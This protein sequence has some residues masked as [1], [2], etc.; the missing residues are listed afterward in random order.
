[1]RLRN[2][3]V[4][5]VCIWVSLIAPVHGAHASDAYPARVGRTVSHA[6]WGALGA[7]TLMIGSAGLLTIYDYQGPWH[8]K[9]IYDQHFQNRQV[10]ST[11][12][13]FGALGLSSAALPTLLTGSLIEGRELR[14][15]VPGHTTFS[16]WIAVAAYA[17]GATS[18][19]I[20]TAAWLPGFSVA[21]V[22]LGIIGFSFSIVQFAH[23]AV[24]ARRLPR[25]DKARLYGPRDREKK[26]RVTLA[27][28]ISREHKG[29]ALVGIF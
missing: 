4:A 17:A 13:A 2:I 16:G 1:M 15:I 9:H 20:G 10:A 19:I 11:A 7:S 29:M 26:L 21:A 23:N 5:L 18:L 25:A 8:N 24:G 14:K 22:H 6:A 12:L 27:P 28:Q 3:L